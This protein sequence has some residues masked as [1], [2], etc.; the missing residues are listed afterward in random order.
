MARDV[1]SE[2]LGNHGQRVSS[3]QQRREPLEMWRMHSVSVPNDRSPTETDS[4]GQSSRTFFLAQQ[5][6]NTRIG[7]EKGVSLKSSLGGRVGLGDLFGSNMRHMVSCSAPCRLRRQDIEE[8]DTQVQVRPA[9]SISK[10]PIAT[11][12]I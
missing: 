6:T 1:T 3:V 2:R 11:S 12:A 8:S 9:K 7:T 5:S 4:R 10:L